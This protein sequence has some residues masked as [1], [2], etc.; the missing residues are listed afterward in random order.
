MGAQANV[1]YAELTDEQIVAIKRRI[2]TFAKTN[3]LFDDLYNHEKWDRGTKTMKSRRVI[4]PKVLK[5]EVTVAVEN[6][7][8]RSQKIAVET[9]QHSVDI[10][11]DKIAYTA[12]DV[13]YGY[14]DIVKIAGDT[15]A[16]ITTQK[17]N[18]IKVKP[19]FLT[20]CEITPEQV[21][22][23]DKYLPTL[24]K[25]AIVL[26]KNEAKPYAR[27]KY[28]AI[29]TP[30]SLELIRGEI[31]AK[32]ASMSEPMKEE[33]ETGIVG[34]YGRWLFKECSHDAFYD[35]TASGDVH[36]VLM[37]LRPNGQKPLDCAK[38]DGVE[39]IHNPLGSGVLVDADG[40]Y[41]A[42]DNKQVGSVAVNVNG[43][44]AFVNDDLCILDCEI[45]ATEIGK[46][47]LA[48]TDKSG[49]VSH[50]PKKIAITIA[51]GNNSKLTVYGADYNSTD[52]KYYATP[53][54]VIKVVV[55]GDNDKTITPATNNFTVTANKGAKRIAEGKT[56]LNYDTAYIELDNG[57]EAFTLT[58]AVVGA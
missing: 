8:P 53:N 48:D 29:V 46:S 9:F 54:T 4:K 14:D 40:H 12:E 21:S 25:A 44:G 41:T 56:T 24:A 3:E 47:V 1:N 5:G 2:E 52:N 37:G 45:A 13:L 20:K 35:A 43:L 17:L 42:D 58:S 7:A 38:I 28:L 49:Y 15:L 33:V 30:E 36:M 10:Y 55:E 32:G 6:V 57:V 27:G 19:L 51:K 22:S 39:V 23:V 34:G 11:R 31:E 18:W 26:Q 50:S 16:E